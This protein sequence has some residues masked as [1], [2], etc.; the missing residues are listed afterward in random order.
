MKELLW[1]AR[2]ERRVPTNAAFDAAAAKLRRG[3]LERLCELNPI[4]PVYS[5][6]TTQFIRALAR[7]IRE[8]KVTRVLEI[9][10][11]DGHLSRC[12]QRAAPD[13]RVTATDSG[14]WEK[15]T[16]RMN[17]AEKRELR[18]KEVAGLAPGPG[19]LRLEAL[20]A[21]R[22]LKPQLVLCSWLPPGP[23]LPK[24][25][26]A[27]RLVL[28]IGAGSGIT[29]DIRAWRYEHDFLDELEALGRCRLDERPKQK[30]HTRVTLYRR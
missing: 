12:L 2:G 17:A 26:R 23:L 29:G 11:G 22:E 15:P 14:A 30:L 18:G 27:A 10:A 16:A 7:T 24:V 28:E 4:A 20:R 3:E 19:V 21:I 13:L 8:L 5:I 6:P 9:A 1:S 25:I